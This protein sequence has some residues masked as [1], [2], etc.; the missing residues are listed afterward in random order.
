MT[1]THSA[2][3][4]PLQ[5]E[6]VWTLEG[7]EIIERRGGQSRRFPL[8]RL[9]TLKVTRDGAIL[10]FGL[11]RM[12][13]PANTY[14]GGLRPQDHTDSFAPFLEAV[15]EAAGHAAPGAKLRTARPRN[16][17]PVVWVMVLMGTGAAALL[18]FAAMAGAWTLGVALAARLL[19]VTILAAAV[20]PWMDRA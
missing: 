19:F 4:S 20:L 15:A 10:G 17:E 5:A 18:L 9:K 7:A 2:R 12:A 8:A 6:T 16:A 14:A 1:P 11:R 3:L 13:I